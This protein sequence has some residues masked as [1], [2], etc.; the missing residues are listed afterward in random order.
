M[1]TI[2]SSCTNSFA[3][4]SPANRM[5]DI[6]NKGWDALKWVEDFSMQH[7]KSFFQCFSCG[8]YLF[9]SRKEIGIA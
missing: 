4:I 3:K 7:T 9:I 1:L 5:I 8:K 2:S 6:N